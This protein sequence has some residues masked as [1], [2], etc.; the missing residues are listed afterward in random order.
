MLGYQFLL[1]VNALDESNNSVWLYFCC[2]PGFTGGGHTWQPRIID[3]GMQS[4]S[5]FS[6]DKITGSSSVSTGDI[7]LGNFPPTPDGT[8]PTDALKGYTFYGRPV[9]MKIGLVTDAY[10]SFT[11]LY[12]NIITTPAF[13]WDTIT[14]SLKGRQEELNKKFDTGKFTGTGTGVNGTANL[15]DVDMPCLLGRAFD[16]T[17]VF[18]GTG[19]QQVYAVS[20]LTGISVGEFGSDF[21]V[22]E[23][24]YELLFNGVVSDV[25]L[26]EPPKGTYSASTSGY[27]RI[28][29][30]PSKRITCSGAQYGMALSATPTNILTS[31]LTWGGFSSMISS[32][33]WNTFNTA[34]HNE[35]G[36]YITSQTSISAIMDFILKPLGYWYYDTNGLILLGNLVDPSTMTSSYTVTGITNVNKFL[37][38]KSSDTEGGIP[39]S[40]VI[41]N[42]GKNYTIQNE[43]ELSYEATDDLKTRVK[44]EWL[45]S[46]STTA[47]L[48][49]PQAQDLI[50]D[51]ALTLV[52][53]AMLSTMYD[54][55][56]VKRDVVEVTLF[57]ITPALFYNICFLHLALCIT[58]D[59]DGRLGYTTKKMLA[60]GFV[61]N[62]VDESATL[63]LW[64]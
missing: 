15:E 16:F 51:T 57:G 10:A 61:L 17:P 29:H 7:I 52:P 8:G 19:G 30:T 20:P 56:T 53:A 9:I 26:A 50:I 37:C 5:L 39:A 44:E 43:S 60:I 4:H 22:Y 27:I 48:S 12:T 21:H 35:R 31:V 34:D 23:G 63:T 47:V 24:M 41:I 49:H 11:T 59:F 64:G 62:L 14:L 18:C 45:K 42:Y 36:M 28:G 54:L 46:K 2:L 6:G 58:V 40:R 25:T 38:K 33:N 3:P 1:E 32:S 13:T 55:H